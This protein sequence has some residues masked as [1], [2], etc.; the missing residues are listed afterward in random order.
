MARYSES[1][2]DPRQEVPTHD[3]WEEA[4]TPPYSNAKC[5]KDSCYVVSTSKGHCVARDSESQIDPHQDAPP[6][7]PWEEAGTHP[8]SALKH[9]TSCCCV[10]SASEEYCMARDLESQIDLLQEAP[11]RSIIQY[12][13]LCNHDNNVDY[14]YEQ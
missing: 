13:E 8:C 1:Q 5:V 9:I 2:I 4:S 11:S 14:S 6:Q 3:P 7:V 10:G 12:S